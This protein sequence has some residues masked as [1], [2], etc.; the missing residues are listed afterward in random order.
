M[1]FDPI[2]VFTTVASSSLWGTLGTALPYVAAGA[3]ALGALQQGSAAAA[4]GQQASAE[5]AFNAQRLEERAA[6]RSVAGAI[7][8]DRVQRVSRLRQGQARANAAGSGLLVEG[9][10]LEVLAFNAGEASR[11]AAIVG[12]QTGMDVEDLLTQASIERTR[13]RVAR[14]AGQDAQDSSFMR[15]GTALLTGPG[16][17]R[18]GGGVDVRAERAAPADGGLSKR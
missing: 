17:W 15:A 12:M 7:E 9:S 5:A 16:M 14:R 3:T 13:G 6:D 11:E 10:P 4:S 8:Q 2:S 1:C 18:R